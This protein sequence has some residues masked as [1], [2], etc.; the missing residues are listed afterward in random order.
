MHS[1]GVTGTWEY[2]PF[3]DF[4]FHL[5]GLLA[6]KSL[7][8]RNKTDETYTAIKPLCHLMVAKFSIWGSGI[9]T[10]HVGRTS[11]AL[12]ILALNPLR[13]RRTSVLGLEPF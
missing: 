5:C 4:S 3:V 8:H 9:L 7:N 1:G 2:L 10:L 11:S 12:R 13:K 6:L